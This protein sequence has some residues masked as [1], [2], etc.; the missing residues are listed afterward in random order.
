MCIHSNVKEEY[1]PAS[2]ILSCAA[3]ALVCGRDTD[4]LARLR[5]LALTATDGDARTLRLKVEYEAW[6]RAAVK[7]GHTPVAGAHAVSMAALRPFKSS[8]SAP[9]ASAEQ[10]NES[11]LASEARANGA[12]V[13]SPTAAAVRELVARA[14]SGHTPPCFVESV[15][16]SVGMLSKVL[17]CVLKE[18]YGRVSTAPNASATSSTVGEQAQNAAHKVKRKTLVRSKRVNTEVLD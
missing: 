12:A 6:R 17:D 11:P 9:S 10:E 2:D 3:M 5:S 15:V 16:E 8:A 1:K 7:R 14:N 13:M 4:P 18:R